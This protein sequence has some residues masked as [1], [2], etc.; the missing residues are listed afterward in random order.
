MPGRVREGGAIGIPIQKDVM[1]RDSKVW[2][3]MAWLR[4][5]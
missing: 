5:Y 4:K 1:S 2:Q 3:S